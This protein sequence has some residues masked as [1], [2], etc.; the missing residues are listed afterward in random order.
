LALGFPAEEVREGTVKVVVPKLEAFKRAAWDYAPSRAP[1][2]Y[3]PLMKL[4][5]D[6]AV[7]AL[8]AYQRRVK[9]ELVV[10]EP[11]AGCGVRGI[12]F[13]KEVEGIGRV[14]LNDINPEAFKLAKHNVQL[15]EL[16]GVVFLANEDA[17]LFLSLHAAPNRRFDY[18]DIDP[19]GTPVYYLDSAIRALRDGGLLALT[20]TD[21]AP[22]CGAYP[23]AAF[24]KYGGVP[25]RT[26]YCHELAIRLLIGCLATVAAKHEIGID[27]QFSYSSGHYVRVYALAAHGAKKADENLRKMGYVLHCFTCL[28]RE[29]VLGVARTFRERCCECG[30]PLKFA[31]PLWLGNI[32]E[33]CFCEQTKKETMS[34][35]LAPK[36]EVMRVL[37]LVKAESDA[38]ATYYVLDSLCD[39]LNVPVPPL[40]KVMERLR[41]RGFRAL[42]T[43]FHSRGIRTDA[44]AK[45][46]TAIVIEAV[47]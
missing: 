21:L 40:A 42:G 26:E 34:K 7:V 37:S 12:R 8:Q 39:K 11:L 20:A 18:I 36:S 4:N 17:N 1:V 6:M 28:H 35:G 43:H 41:E 9:R 29:T 46:M 33:A 31:G 30:S 22:L 5:R 13:A 47:G 19:S 25:L 2:F 10:S 24:R 14:H 44:P 3:N 15:N 45:T 27:I 23:K 16:A 32:A 38:P